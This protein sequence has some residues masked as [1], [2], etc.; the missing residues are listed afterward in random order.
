R[1]NYESNALTEAAYDNNVRKFEPVDLDAL[2]GEFP[3]L[4]VVHYVVDTG[5]D[6]PADWR[7]VA[8]D[9]RP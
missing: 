2:V 7:V 9:E 1:E 8:R 3:S 4:R 6:D 5:S